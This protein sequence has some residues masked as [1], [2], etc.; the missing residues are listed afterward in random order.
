MW[1]SAF[2]WSNGNY[3]TRQHGWLQSECHVHMQSTRMIGKRWIL[4]VFQI[5]DVDFS[6]E[7]ARERTITAACMK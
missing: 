3:D 6:G 5:K 7:L 4:R 1:A 2:E